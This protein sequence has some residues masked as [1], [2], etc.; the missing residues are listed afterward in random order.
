M[1]KRIRI[2]KKK[3][4]TFDRFECHRHLRVKRNWRRP[5]GIDCSVRRKFRGMLRTPKVGY[6]SN[7][8]TRNL[9]PNYKLKFT[10]NNLKELE[11]LLMNNDKYCVEIGK[12]VGAVLRA[13][14]LRRAKELNPDG[15]VVACGCYVQVA[16]D[17]VDG[18]EEIDLSIGTT[19]P[20]F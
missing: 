8:K 13:Q 1:S 20:K 17:V 10:V 2:I 4:T 5:R 19:K 14:M 16:K 11:C 7:K 3:K 18:I 12:K 6:G 9:L 15:I